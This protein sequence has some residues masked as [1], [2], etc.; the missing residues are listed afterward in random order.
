MNYNT[1]IVKGIPF[2][3]IKRNYKNYKAERF[4]INNTNQNIWIPN[5]CLSLDGTI[6]ENK[7]NWILSNET[8]KRKI[9]L[10]GIDIF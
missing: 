1:Q 6:I 3:L 8:I 4:T 2:K 9:K 5:N 10:A 7:I